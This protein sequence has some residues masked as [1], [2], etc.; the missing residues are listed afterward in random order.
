MQVRNLSARPNART[1]WRENVWALRKALGDT[2]GEHAYIETIPK[3]G[4]L[5]ARVAV[6]DSGPS[7]SLLLLHHL[8]IRA[9]LDLFAQVCA[10]IQHAHQKGVI[11]RDIKPSN[12]LVTIQDDR[13]VPKV[14]DFGVAKAMHRPLT[15]KTFFTEH[16]VLI[17]TPEYMSPEQ[18]ER[19]GLA[20]DTRTDIYSLGVLLY[21]LLVGAVPFDSIRLRQAGYSEIQR[22]IR[23]EEP[24]RPSTRLTSLGVIADDIAERR[25]A[26]VN[27]LTRELRGD[28]DWIT[29]KALEKDRGRRY[30]SASELAADLG[31]HLRDEPIIAGS[32]SAAYRFASLRRGIVEASSPAQPSSLR[33]L[34]SRPRQS[35]TSA[36]R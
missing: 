1:S 25:G 36:L 30:S 6:R 13:P 22:I 33:W 32:P 20:V 29:L 35:C 19:T 15:E 31:R 14:I 24:V 3:V 9:R 27:V 4:Y 7:D 16:G 34:A 23:E 17:G 11:H 26:T 21:E 8:S 10:A 2:N 5:F 18:A 12:V 28:L